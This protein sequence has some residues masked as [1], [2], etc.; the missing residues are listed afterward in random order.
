MFQESRN[1]WLSAGPVSVQFWNSDR[2]IY[3]GTMF[4]SKKGGLQDGLRMFPINVQM[5]YR[6]ISSSALNVLMNDEDHIITKNIESGRMI[7]NSSD[8]NTVIEKMLKNLHP[9]YS[10]TLMCG[11]MIMYNLAHPIWISIDC[12]APLLTDLICILPRNHS[13]NHTDANNKRF[14]ST[15]EC[16]EKQILLNG[17]CLTFHMIRNGWMAKNI[18][19]KCRILEMKPL[20]VSEIQFL[21]PIITA[22]SVRFPPIIFVSSEYNLIK[23]T[24]S[25]LFN[26]FNPETEV[27]NG[28]TIPTNAMFVCKGAH[29]KIHLKLQGGNIF[30]CSS[31]EYVSSQGICDGVRNCLS[32]DDEHGCRDICKQNATEFS[33]QCKKLCSVDGR[34]K[35]SP[36]YFMDR[37]GICQSFENQYSQYYAS[38]SSIQK[39]W[40]CRNNQTIALS[41][42]NDIIP[43]CKEA[44]D[45]PL[46]SV[47]LQSRGTRKFLCSLSGQLPCLEGHSHCFDISNICVYNLDAFGHLSP[48]RTGVHLTVCENFTCNNKYKCPSYYCLRFGYLCDGKNDCPFGEDEQECDNMSDCKYMYRCRGSKQC[49]HLNDICDN[50]KDCKHGDDETQCQLNHLMCPAGCVCLYFAVYCTDMKTSQ[51]EQGSVALPYISLVINNQIADNAKNIFHTFQMISVATFTN[52]S[53]TSICGVLSQNRILIILDFSRNQIGKLTQNCFYNITNAKLVNISTNQISH[54]GSFS[55]HNLCNINV[56]DLSVNFVI[57]LPSYFIRDDCKGGKLKYF[58]IKSNPVLHISMDFLPVS[59]AVL[60]A[61][62]Y[63]V[64]CATLEDSCLVEKAW[65]ESC[66][67]LLATLSMKLSMVSVSLIIIFGNL[68]SFVLH[69]YAIHEK[70]GRGAYL[71]TCVAINCSDMCLGIYTAII[72]SVDI[73]YRGQFALWEAIW[74]SHGLCYLA[75]A[76]SLVFSLSSPLYLTFLSVSRIMVI[77]LPFHTAFKNRKF[78]VKCL[79]SIGLLV[80]AMA[81]FPV[82]NCFTKAAQISTSLCTVFGGNSKTLSIIEITAIVQSVLQISGSFVILIVYILLFYNL[83]KSSSIIGQANHNERASKSLVTQLI[84]LTSSNIVCWLP[85]SVVYL[86]SVFSSEYSMS[87]LIWT[88]IAIT[89]INS[90]INPV[91]LIA[92]TLRKLSKETHKLNKSTSRHLPAIQKESA[93]QPDDFKS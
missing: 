87:L 78:V 5:H 19:D 31:G 80:F 39:F 2:N 18:W 48:C 34:C 13:N 41:H 44:E 23:F 55:F 42:F 58:S 24:Y 84:V 52:T 27:I 63:R 73:G 49:I 75:L 45:E 76:I 47:L 85:S 40:H 11:M 83:R 61:D 66:S 46:L 77:V 26:R 79:T 71:V 29:R 22:T 59:V 64:C 93:K 28:E 8:F 53:L 62:T 15:R 4:P 33:S 38:L 54:I 91:V 37:N 70:I 50:Y 69:V 89:P 81:M 74:R 16:K 82:L 14:L 67:D 60:L 30:L 32:G 7:E 25:F 12:H 6:W 36:L 51:I 92:G 68:F 35:C 1:M 10:E 43:D 90:V 56:I 65:Y 17:I 57:N 72:W 3:N 86:Y 21:H 20:M 88:T 9:I